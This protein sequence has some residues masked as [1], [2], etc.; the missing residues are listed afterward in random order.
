MVGADGVLRVVERWAAE[1][2]GVSAVTAL[3]R[4]AKL[5]DGRDAMLT[6][7][8]GPWIL[9]RAS[10]AALATEDPRGLA[11]FTRR[12]GCVQ[13]GGESARGAPSP[14]LLRR[15]PRLGHQGPSNSAWSLGTLLRRGERLADKLPARA[16]QIVDGLS[17]QDLAN[18]AWRF[19]KV[20]R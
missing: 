4:I 7:D 3:N 19:R 9:Q 17:H 14:A 8:F 13:P 11:N 15:F 12:A 1:L 6:S 20:S 5:K 16:T 10:V 18:G 2:S